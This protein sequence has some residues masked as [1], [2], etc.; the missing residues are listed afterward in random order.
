[1]RF[2][3]AEDS[4]DAEEAYET[5]DGFEMDSIYPADLDDTGEG[6]EE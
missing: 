6:P 3:W 1:M 5:E 4:S 2:R